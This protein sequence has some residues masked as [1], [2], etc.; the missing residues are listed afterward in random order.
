[1]GVPKKTNYPS[2]TLTR[3]LLVTLFGVAV[4]HAHSTHITRT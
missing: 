1:M 4:K 2:V 3:I